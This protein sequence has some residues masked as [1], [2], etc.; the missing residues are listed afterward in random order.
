MISYN[1][2][3]HIIYDIIDDIMDDIMYDIRQLC[4][5]KYHICYHI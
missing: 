4:I 2:L 1:T 3:P 5:I